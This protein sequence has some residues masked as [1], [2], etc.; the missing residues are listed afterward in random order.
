MAQWFRAHW[1]L[2]Q[3]IQGSRPTIHP[4]GSTQ[5]ATTI[6]PGDLASS[7]GSYWY[8]RHSMDIQTDRIPIH[9]KNKF[10]IYKLIYINF[11]KA[12]TSGSEA[13]W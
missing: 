10:S 6:V 12:A 1:L 3:R 8:C 7:S 5:K 11:K 4:H 9:I 2:S 13:Q